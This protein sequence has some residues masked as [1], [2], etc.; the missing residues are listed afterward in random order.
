MSRWVGARSRRGPICAA[1]KR[2]GCRANASELARAI[3][4]MC[5]G[6]R[7]RTKA[8]TLQARTR[9]QG[10]RLHNTLVDHAVDSPAGGRT[11]EA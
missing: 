5:G 9:L 7:A 1:G 2:S 11:G 3:R 10:P 6:W 8:E 4:N